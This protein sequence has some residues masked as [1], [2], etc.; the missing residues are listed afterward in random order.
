MITKKR[1]WMFWKNVKT[2]AGFKKFLTFLIFVSIAALFWFILALNDSILDDFEVRVN[3][4]NVPD[5]VTFINVPPQKIHVMVRDQ[6]TNLWRNGIFSHATLNVNFR[7]YGA[8]GIFRMSSSELTA[9][10]KNVFGP[11]ATLLSAS[12]DSLVLAYTTLPGKRVPVIV[13]ADLSPAVGKIISATPY[14]MPK[15]VV[16]YSTSGILDTVSHVYTD[17]FS[18]R[19]LEE[20][21]EVPVHLRGIR[22]VRIEPL[23]VNVHIEVEP[24][25]RKRASVNIGVENLPPNLELLLFPSST[26][27]EYYMPMSKFNANAQEKVEVAVDYSDLKEGTHKLPL[28]LI[29]HEPGLLNMRLLSDSVEFTLVRN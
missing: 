16:V 29:H 17:H 25:V 3:V 2:S 7:D 22:G 8:D 15:N 27:V 1:V 10:L 5:S 13:S 12:V 11:S 19:N 9:S 24:L 26:G 6:A 14:A 20:S 23:I 4:Y 28:R 18:R 21:A